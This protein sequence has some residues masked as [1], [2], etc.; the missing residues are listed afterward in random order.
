MEGMPAAAATV[1]KLELV[2]DVP[3]VLKFRDDVE[4]NDPDAALVRLPLTLP[5]MVMLEAETPEAT[6]GL[7]K[8]RVSTLVP[9]S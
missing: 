4:V 6:T 2:T 3:V 1:I 9:T 5:V 8:L 7:E